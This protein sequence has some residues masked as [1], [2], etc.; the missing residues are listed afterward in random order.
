MSDD[1]LF[2]FPR[3]ASGSERITASHWGL[4]HPQVADGRLTGL[5]PYAG[6]YAPSPNLAKFAAL[7]Y[8]ANRIRKPAV[9]EGWLKCRGGNGESRGS[10]RFVEVDW[11][12][13]MT[14]AA[15]AM[16]GVY[17]NFGPSAVFAK[18][19]GWMSPG[20]VNSAVTLVN[21]LCRLMGGFTECVNSYSTAAIS[22]ILPYVVGMPDPKVK[23]WDSV[24]ANAKCVVFWGADPLITC[25]IDWTTTLH[26]AAHHI[27][28][29][30]ESGIRTIVINPLKTKTGEFLGS[31][32]I[33]PRQGT[34]TA[35][36][37]ALIRELITTGR[38]D[39]GFLT[40]YTAG[41]ETL[42]AY[43]EG[44]TDGTAKTAEWAEKITGVQARVIRELAQ[45]LAQN[46]TMLMMGWGMQRA[47][48]GEEA[49]W[50]GFALAAMLGQMNLAGGGI[51]TN[52]HYCSGGASVGFGPRLR[53][54][55]GRVAPA[56][57]VKDTGTPL[58]VIPIARFAD[59]FLNPGETI[60]FNGR[61][62]TY[63]D[64][65][66]V[67]W[68]GGNP[69]AHQ[70]QTLHLER[71]WQ[72]PETVIVT[73]FVWT[74]TARHAD[75][76]FP[77]A[78]VFERNDI[79]DIGVYNNAG[80]CT[81]QQ[82]VHPVGEARSDYRI[83]S[84]LSERLGVGDAFTLGRSETDWIRTIY[85]EARTS[86]LGRATGLPD[87]ETFW[88]TGLIR[89]APDKKATETDGLA[90]FFANPD[91]FPLATPSGRIELASPQIAAMHYN[92]CP[93]YPAFLGTAD[94][95]LKADPAALT[96]MA[97]KSEARL[98]SQLGG[99]ITDGDGREACEI[100]PADALT[101]GIA[102]GDAVLVY[103][104]RGR[105][106]ARARITENV[107]RGSVCI[108]HGAWFDPADTSE[109]R[110]DRTGCAN[111]LTPDTGTS[112]LAQ[113]NIASGAAVFVK[114]AQGRQSA[115]SAFGQ[116]AF[117]RP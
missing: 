92:D 19:Y 26:E 6:D 65:R 41:W 112:R 49:S 59:A 116:P 99:V 7:S 81:M 96:L 13:A 57:A 11:D 98:H 5:I 28:R 18:S 60:D 44:R 86:P 101:R 45:Y 90:A 82:A 80:L 69:F 94:E 97:V 91:A 42:E 56:R 71:A 12:T 8:S 30:K 78:T 4:V 39:T 113:G 48:Y 64:I 35:L 83:F 47:L 37:L 93:G 110:I 114:K 115:P 55:T 43:V 95:A 105:L 108:R 54:I 38:A 103:N 1:T 29:L 102:N 77:A 50:A 17:D 46:R 75:I 23:S 74:A 15:E 89:Y 51:G 36:M 33:A 88:K 73:D 40:K 16:T 104:N 21:R 87:F 68:S 25:D 14:L 52:Y 62:V 72:K 85:E 67:L 2:A 111:V 27:R 70:P 20:K 76:V 3:N 84:D 63:P 107:A 32:W 58:P 24:L 10:D 34:D 79:T 100:H 106:L 66:L 109:G 117:S 31:D 53:G 9:R 61:K 22:T